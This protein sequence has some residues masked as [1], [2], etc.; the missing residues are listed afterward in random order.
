[1]KTIYLCGA[2]ETYEGTN[3]ARVW[4]ERAK[5]YFDKYSI[6]FECIS[7]VDYYNYGSNV[8]QRD[9]EIM[10]FDLRKVRESDILLVNLNDIR[11]SV[12]TCD[13]IFLAYVLGK[14]IIGFINKD[15]PNK[16]IAQLVH[17]WKY[18]QID[19]IEV[20]DNSLSK[21]CEYIKDYYG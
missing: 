19:R 12:G 16:E 1:M 15:V 6:N 2:M 9:S 4:R 10:R 5:E 17:P 3:E 13:E 20:G 8:A 18:E 21:A 11:K 7:P 14:P